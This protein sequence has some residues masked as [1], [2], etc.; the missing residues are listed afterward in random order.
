MGLEFELDM[1]ELEEAIDKYPDRLAKNL[2][3]ASKRSAGLVEDYASQNHRYKDRTT[4]LT[5]S[6][7]G[8]SQANEV[9]LV[10]GDEGSNFGTEYG[11][12]IHQGFG[13]WGADKFIPNSISKNKEKIFKNWQ[14]A[15]DETNKGF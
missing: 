11:K 8:Y 1:S 9:K 3:L 6:I 15:I 14:R 12:Y 2:R 10:L 4:R 13:S 5:K 7:I